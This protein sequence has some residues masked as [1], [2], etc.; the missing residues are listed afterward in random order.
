MFVIGVVVAAVAAACI[1][2]GRL[3][4]RIRDDVTGKIFLGLGGFFLALDVALVKGQIWW[5]A[6]VSV[7][8]GMVVGGQ[9]IRKRGLRT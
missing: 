3:L 9:L 7:A 6:P 8:A 1:A 5:L 2:A 4:S